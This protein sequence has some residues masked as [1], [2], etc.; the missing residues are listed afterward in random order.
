M[1]RRLFAIAI[2]VLGAITIAGCAKSEGKYAGKYISEKTVYDMRTKKNV[3]QILEIKK[4]GTWQI[5]PALLG[6]SSDGEWKID[7]D[8]ITLYA[9]KSRIP[10]YI[11]RL[12]KKKLIDWRGEIFTK[13]SAPAPDKSAQA[14]AQP[15]KA[16]PRPAPA[17]ERP[18]E[19]SAPVP[20]KPA[21]A[22]AQPAEARPQPAPAPERPAEASAPPSPLKDKQTWSGYYTCGQGKTSLILKISSVLEIKNT[23]ILKVEAIFDFNHGNGRAVG[24][25]NLY[26]QYNPKNRTFLLNPG[27]WI[28]Q[29]PGYVTVGMDGKISSNG[30]HYTGKILYS[31]CSEFD[32]SLDE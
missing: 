2:L 3:Q 22:P 14:P 1:R 12:E 15:A 32:L 4:D 18:A 20:D 21:Q 24:K 7:K 27:D 19:A 9:G 23:D 31:G 30:K 17:P 26:G 16:R 13:A 29:P 28:Q 25:Y 11:M 5:S 10:S 8:G 6:V